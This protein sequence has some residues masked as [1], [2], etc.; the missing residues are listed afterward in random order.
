M[1]NLSQNHI[2]QESFFNSTKN[3]TS[4]YCL[5]F[6]GDVVKKPLYLKVGSED[7][8]LKEILK[9][10]RKFDE[11]NPPPFVDCIKVHPIKNKKETDIKKI[12][13]DGN[14]YDK[15]PWSSTQFNVF[16]LGIISQNALRKDI[17]EKT[18]RHEPSVYSRV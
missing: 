15:V 9:R 8:L 18:A 5:A 3:S 16:L 17:A 6:E 1:T 11:S 4:I 10:I 14:L 12:K 13:R 7:N 2:Y